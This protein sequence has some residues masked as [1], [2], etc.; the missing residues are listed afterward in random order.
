VH[1]LEEFEKNTLVPRL[2][3]R[4][5][6]NLRSQFA[7]LATTPPAS[8]VSAPAPRASSEASPQRGKRRQLVTSIHCGWKD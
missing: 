6:P 8:P 2:K 7:T 5:P 4:L 3:K 1:L